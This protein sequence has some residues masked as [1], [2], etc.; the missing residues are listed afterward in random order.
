MK[1][2]KYPANLVLLRGNHESR[3]S[4][5]VYGFYDEILNKYGNCKPWRLFMDVFD[6]LPLAALIDGSI[7]C[8]HGG[9]SKEISTID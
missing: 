1:I 4:T 6:C 3:S 7:F 5:Q 8:V 9:L 2:V